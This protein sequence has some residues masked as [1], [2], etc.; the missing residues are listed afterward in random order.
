M[1][2]NEDLF[3]NAF[4]KWLEQNGVTYISGDSGSIRWATINLNKLKIAILAREENLL[5]SLANQIQEG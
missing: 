2:E 4:Y 3:T 1:T 5:R